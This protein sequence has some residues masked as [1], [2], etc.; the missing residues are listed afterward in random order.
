MA[1]VTIIYFSGAGTTDIYAKAI[2]KGI[3]SNEAVEINLISINPE[4]IHQGKY[5]NVSI[6]ES[7]NETDTIVFGSPTYMGG[8]A[9]QFKAFADATNITWIQQKWKDKLAAGFTISGAPSGDKL[10]TLHYLQ[11]FAM[12]HGMLWISTG[13]N[14]AQQ[15]TNRL[16][17]WAGAMAQSLHHI[18][19]TNLDGLI[20]QEDLS[21]AELFGK[22]IADVTM[23]LN[24]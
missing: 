21:Y 22:R 6:I 15:S 18:D 4:D 11:A 13:E 12:Q 3:V 24:S 16:G 14:I 9:A 5:K 19:N 23:K 7:L 20:S 17:S 10:N 2:A 8:V 1:K